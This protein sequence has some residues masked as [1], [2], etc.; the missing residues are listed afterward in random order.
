[1][2]FQIYYPKLTVTCFFCA[3]SQDELL[4]YEQKLFGLGAQPV[5]P[6][7]SFASLGFGYTKPTGDTQAPT[8]NQMTVPSIFKRV[9]PNDI[10]ANFTFGARRM[11]E[12]NPQDSDNNGGTNPASTDNVMDSS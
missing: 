12:V 9:S 4:E 10:P 3:A 5:I 1:V 8:F 2:T 6:T 7:E 11:V